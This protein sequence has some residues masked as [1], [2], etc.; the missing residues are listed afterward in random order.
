MPWSPRSIVEQRK[1]LV[2]A[3]LEP[4]ANH[5]EVCRAHGISRQCGYKWVKR[6]REQGLSGLEE[7]SRRPHQSPLRVEGELVLQVLELRGQYPKWGPKKL[8]QVLSRRGWDMPSVRTVA[9]ILD[10]ADVPKRRTGRHKHRAVVTE[11]PKVVAQAP[12]EL[13]SADFKGWWKTADERRC[14]PLTVRDMYSRFVLAIRCMRS[15]AYRP[16][17]AEF[18]QLFERCGLP[19]AI[20]VD[21][22]TPF[23]NGQSRLGLTRLSAWWVSLG[24]EVRHTRPAHPQDNGAHE[25][26]HADMALELQMY[27]E[28]DLR[29]QQLACEAWQHDFNHVRPHEA[30]DMQVPDDLYR[31]S[32][33]RYRAPRIVH[34]PDGMQTRKVSTRGRI[35]HEGH[36][37]AVGRPFEGYTVGVEPLES[38]KVRVWF[39]EKDLGEFSSPAA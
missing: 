37:Y 3:L 13:W 34:Y 19:R 2:L 36:V 12:N 22:G 1:K 27:P 33:R 30:L 29:R 21:N 26:M 10:R 20:V 24:I 8:R 35:H 32:K 9:R 6:Y 5:A 18:E 17:Q 28:A 38:H 15:T 25:R 7:H 4:G 11:A 14:E 23:G 39:Y 31:P 16:T